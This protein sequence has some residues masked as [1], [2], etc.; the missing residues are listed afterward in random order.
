MSNIE[1]KLDVL[2]QKATPALYAAPLASR[3]AAGFVGRLFIDSD[4]PSTGLYRDTGTTWVQVADETGSI[5]GFVPYT[6]ATTNV[7]LGTNNITAGSL[8]KTG[9]TSAQILAGDGTVITAGTNITITGGTIAASG[10]SGSQN[11][12]SVTTLGNTTNTGI[13]V[14]AN[15]IGIGTTI[16][17]SNRLDIHSA[18]GIN[19][20]LNGT[21]VTNSCL[22]LE[23]AGVGKWKIQ[24]NYNAGANDFILT[25]VLN[26]VNRLIIKNTAL[27]TYT[28]FFNVANI[29]G[30]QNIQISGTAPA[31]TIIDTAGSGY[32]ASIGMATVGNNFISGSVLGDLCIVNQSAT[33][34]NLKLAVTSTNTAAIN[35]TPANRVGIN[36]STDNGFQLDVNGNTNITG[37]LTVSGTTPSIITFNRQSSSYTLAITDA[38]LMV[39]MNVATANNLTIPLNS[40]VPFAIGQIIELTQYG[41]GQTTIVATSGVTINSYTGLT[42]LSGQY[43]AATLTKVGTNEWYLF[44]NLTV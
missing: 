33:A 2:N 41:A 1:V 3:P 28:G 40:S 31:Y 25:D 6:G 35:I 9:G 4:N 16:P 8:I 27:A 10:G 15:G 13:A 37:N 30:S 34:K 21:G 19:A 18:T 11:L 32:A 36:T 5:S 12:Q 23:S 29:S 17:S 39:E 22:Q 43:A 7:D 26:T 14:S 38:G 24:N 42:K 20:S 44:G